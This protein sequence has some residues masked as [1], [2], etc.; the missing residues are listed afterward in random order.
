M[1]KGLDTKGPAVLGETLLTPKEAVARGI[2][3][4]KKGRR[5]QEKKA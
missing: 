1:S 3:S 4:Y 5:A 2:Q